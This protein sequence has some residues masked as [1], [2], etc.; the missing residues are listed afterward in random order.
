[1]TRD[2]IDVW[3]VNQ[4]ILGCVLEPAVLCFIALLTPG[5]IDLYTTDSVGL[6]SSFRP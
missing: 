6:P 4:C 2:Y 3:E 1:M 5:P